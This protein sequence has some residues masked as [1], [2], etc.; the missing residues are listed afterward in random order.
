VEKQMISWPESEWFASCSVVRL[1]AIILSM[2]LTMVGTMACSDS[3]ARPEA[4]QIAPTEIVIEDHSFVQ[5]HQY[6][7]P[8]AVVRWVNRD[9]VA[10]MVV[11][12]TPDDAGRRFSSDLIR[13]GE[14]YEH[15]FED[16][17]RFRYHC[18]L[19]TGRIR[20]LSDMPVLFVRE[21]TQPGRP[22]QPGS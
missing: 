13:P 7:V 17:G 11:S 2:A 14:V 10:H 12:G 8:G 20:T 15:E 6:A 21:Q 3:V 5:L 18:G 19:H 16:S 4:S 22:S 9:E 1:F